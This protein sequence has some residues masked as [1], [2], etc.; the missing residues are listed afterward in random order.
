MYCLVSEK[1]L[2][3]YLWDK[4]DVLIFRDVVLEASDAAET[5]RLEVP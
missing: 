4:L 3:G 5:E 1:K 2:E